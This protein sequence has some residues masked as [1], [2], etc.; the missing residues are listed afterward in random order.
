[1]VSK[2]L[3]LLICICLFLFTNDKAF[4]QDDDA[5]EAKSKI[6]I[7][8]GI[9]SI[10]S[11]SDLDEGIVTGNFK[12]ANIFYMHKSKNILT[13]YLGFGITTESCTF[14]YAILH[15]N[16]FPEFYEL[17]IENR[18]IGPVFGVQFSTSKFGLGFY[19]DLNFEIKFNQ[20][21]KVTSR[22]NNEITDLSNRS[23][24]ILPKPVNIH[25]NMRIGIEYVW[26]NQFSTYFQLSGGRPINAMEI[27]GE[28]NMVEIPKIQFFPWHIGPKVGIRFP[29]R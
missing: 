10:N 7:E 21:T 3:S 14:R 19:G 29:L 16:Q 1:M 22:T 9:G 13:P 8:Y 26:K 23:N 11:Y 27:I 28:L 17:Y 4:T 20:F 18:A 24:P 5:F 2:S 25:Y 15:I 12:E 6:S